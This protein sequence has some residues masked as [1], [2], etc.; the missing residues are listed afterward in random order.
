MM[1]KVTTRVSALAL[2]VMLVLGSLVMVFAASPAVVD[3]SAGIFTADQKTEI[4]SRFD[5]TGSKTGWQLIL[6]TSKQGVSSGLS[7]YY[8]Q[9]YVDR[10]S[11]DA[12]AVI[13]V[14]DIGSNKG[15]V[16]SHGSA[17]SY[18]SDQRLSEMGSMLRGYLDSKDYY[19]GALAFADKLDRFYADGIP[20]GD[21]YSNVKTNEKADN[22]LLYVLKHY[23]WIFGIVAV[24]AG[25][26]FFAVNNH[27]YKNLGKSGTYDLAANS[28]VE[29]NEVQDDFVTQHTTVHVIRSES[30]SGGGSSG[31]SGGSSHGGGDF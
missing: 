3:D 29:L 2:A 1:K 24:A 23:G 9:N 26:I 30:S 28:K 14:F 6:Y 11:H 7:D 21:S 16:I 27:R 8:N 10:I 15:A 19:G 31:S 18:I 13:L 5:K 22:K 17:E 4:A 25:V 20:G 12:D